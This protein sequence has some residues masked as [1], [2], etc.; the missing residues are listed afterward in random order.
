MRA[1]QLT[2]LCRLWRLPRQS[3]GPSSPASVRPA[4]AALTTAGP[5]A[6]IPV[7]PAPRE[8]PPGGPVSGVPAPGRAQVLLVGNDRRFRAVAS[9]L[10]SRRGHAVTVGGPDDDV[11]D[12]AVRARADVVLIDAGASLTA[13]ARQ[14]ARLDALRPRV[15]VFTVGEES[16]EG[17]AT[18]PVLFKW[19]CLHQVMDAIDRRRMPVTIGAG[20]ALR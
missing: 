12:L 16:G 6:P 7:P 3:A 4:P 20:D 13:A 17:L 10:L 1:A 5:T 18:L 14:A 19:S 11:V 9:T 2:S 8:A 15:T